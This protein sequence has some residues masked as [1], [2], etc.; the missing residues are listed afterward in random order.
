MLVRIEL[1]CH[2]THSDGSLSARDLAELAF[3]REVRLFCLTDHDTC[4]G[5]EATKAAFPDALRGVELSCT[6]DDHTVHLLLY[7]RGGD[8]QVVQEALEAQRQERRDRVHTIAERLADLGVSLD[9]DALLARVDGSIGRP[10]IAEAL[11]QN[12][13]VKSREEAFDRYLKDEGP[14]DVKVARLSLADGLALGNTAG[15]AMALAHPHVHG[16]RAEALLR[17]YRDEGLEGLEVYYGL[18]AN[19]KRRKYAALARELDLVAT[20]GSDFHGDALPK[21]ERPGIDVEAEVAAPLFAWL[22]RETP[23]S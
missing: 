16:K 23:I 1:H 20:V 18:Y 5:F 9:A 3:A 15:A 11:V 22:G 2:S 17:R 4:A 12:G 10:H 7:D 8:W 14:A 19:K 6:E 21:V 13:A